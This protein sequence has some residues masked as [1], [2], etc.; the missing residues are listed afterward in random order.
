MPPSMRPIVNLQAGEG[1]DLSQA[2]AIF[3]DQALVWPSLNGRCILRGERRGESA[4]RRCFSHQEQPGTV[5]SP[6]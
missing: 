2:P 6:Q 1:S 5:G 3:F 4:R